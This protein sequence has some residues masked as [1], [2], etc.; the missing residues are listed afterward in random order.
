MIAFLQYLIALVVATHALS[1]PDLPAGRSMTGTGCSMQFLA[2][3]TVADGP[4]RAI[5]TPLRQGRSTA[6]AE[7]ELFQG[8]RRIAKGTFPFLFLD[9]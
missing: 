6:V 4:L 3:A 9:R 8:E 2:A 1:P 5:A 7:S